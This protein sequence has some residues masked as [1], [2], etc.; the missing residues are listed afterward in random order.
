MENVS[1]DVHEG[2]QNRAGAQRADHEPDAREGALSLVECC[3]FLQGLTCPN[4]A[5]SIQKESAQLPGVAQSQVNLVRQTL[6]VVGTARPGE[7]LKAVKN[8]VSRHEPHVQ[9]TFGD[10]ARASSAIPPDAATDKRHILRLAVG[11]GLYLTLCAVSVLITLAPWLCAVLFALVYGLLGGDVLYKAGRNILRGR[12]F[13]ENLLMSVSTLG[14]FAI[15]EYPE[16]VAVML[17]YQ[18]GEYFQDKAVR[19]SRTSITSLLRMKATQAWVRREG[20]WVGLDPSEVRP[21]EV[22]LVKPGER[23]PLDGIV[24]SGACLLDRRFLTGESLPQRAEPGDTILSGTIC[25]DGAL[26]IRAEK[27]YADSTVARIIR[28]V[29]DATARKAPAEN[30]ITTFARWYT[31]TVVGLALLLAVLPP[32]L[33]GGA[34]T[35]WFRRSCIFLVISCPCALVIS[36]PLA[37]FG[38]IGAASRHGILVKGGNFLEALRRADIFVFD[39]TGTLTKGTF[40]VVGVLPAPGMAEEEI[41]RLAAA[42]ECLSTHPIARSI[43][44]AA[45]GREASGVSAFTE[46]AGRGVSA[47]YQ[48]L[49][50]LVGSR[51]L[52]QE[53]GVACPPIASPHTQVYVAVDGVYAGCLLIADTPKPGSAAA[54]RAL[55][56][57]GAR[58]IAM[59]TGD[60][61]KSAAAA[62]QAL[63]IHECHANLLPQDKVAWLDQWASR[64]GRGHTLCFVGDGVNDSP[65]IARADVG[66]AMGALGTDA[67]IEAADVVLMSDDPLRL[68]E[69]VAIARR[70]HT[71]VMQNIVFALG[72]KGLLLILGALGLATLWEAVFG[73]VGVL[74]LAVLNAMRLLKTDTDQRPPSTEEAAQA[75]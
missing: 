4:C 39:K 56:Q 52:L 19:R 62:A 45:A 11:A 71:I 10:D 70:T 42:A 65:A 36:V 64:D 17:F 63:G 50:L 31:P 60:G 54:I 41:L 7:L 68:P 49:R 35:E 32:L 13:D 25:L 58:R 20:Q 47:A 2:L 14:A 57:L 44:R 18:I 46:I 24:L 38:G 29:E 6:T 67:A 30:F 22:F 28:M 40:E 74:I 3:F 43:V 9:V 59:L 27:P 34:W 48:G 53:W 23:V 12:V 15:G 66:I 33:L 55:R 75:A 26:E 69:A 21:G 37:F 72:I 1:L 5:A 61:E 73:D 8:I 51:T 16:A